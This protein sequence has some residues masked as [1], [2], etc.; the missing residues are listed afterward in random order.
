LLDG[1]LMANSLHFVADKPKLIKQ[2]E[3]GF[4][5]NPQL[6]IVEYDAAK[7]NPWAPYPISFQKLEVEFTLLGYKTVKLAQTPSRFGGII[8]SALA[9]K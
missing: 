7:S 1:V 8:Y 9:I 4:K 3:K 2:L 5:A 6:L